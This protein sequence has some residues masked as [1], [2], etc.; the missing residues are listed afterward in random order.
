MTEHKI[1]LRQWI[2]SDLEPFTAM[3]ANT[4]VMKFFL[5]A[6]SHDE[7][8][9]AFDRFR[10]SIEKRGWGLWA[11]EVDGVFAGFTGLSEPTYTTHF[12]PCVEIGWRFLPE[13]WG[14]G[15]AYSAAQMAEDHAFR[16]LKLDQLVS[17]TT[18]SN[19]RS[20]RLMERLRFTRDPDDDFDH[21]VAP[22]GHPLIRHVLYKKKN[23]TMK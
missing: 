4:E 14:K 6:L 22:D 12:T 9:K 5:T 13:Y 3:N 19:I 2:D 20:R 8:Q 1:Q 10:E 7:S 16:V 17:Y 23:P 18:E 15:I 11:V 21:P